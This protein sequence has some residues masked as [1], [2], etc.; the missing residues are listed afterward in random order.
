MLRLPQ[1]VHVVPAKTN[2][3]NTHFEAQHR[4]HLPRILHF[5]VRKVLPCCEFCASRLAKCSACHEIYT[6]RFKKRCALNDLC[7][8][9]FTKR[10]PHHEI[11]ITS[12]T[13]P[14]ASHEICM[15]RFTNNCCACYLHHEVRKSAPPATEFTGLRPTNAEL[16]TRCAPR[17][18]KGCKILVPPSCQRCACHDLHIKVQ[19]RRRTATKSRL[20]ATK[21]QDFLAPALEYGQYRFQRYES[22]TA[23]YRNCHRKI[24]ICDQRLGWLLVVAG[25]CSMTHAA[26]QPAIA[27]KPD[28]CKQQ[29]S[30]IGA[31]NSTGSLNLPQ[32]K[33]HSFFWSVNCRRNSTGPIEIGL[34][35]SSS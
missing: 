10:C 7:T 33:Q 3:I 16:A 31:C 27:L 4:L 1:H 14:S 20:H 29:C 9:S 32:W 15:S 17:F 28:H 2:Y 22:Y 30:Q 13:K 23:T 34:R 26:F 8:L 18:T 25:V 35:L 24:S 11:C 5:E 12:F 6:L 21:A 19:R